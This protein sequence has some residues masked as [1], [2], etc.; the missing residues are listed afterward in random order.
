MYSYSNLNKLVGTRSTAVVATA[1]ACALLTACAAGP[2][3]PDGADSLR[4]RLTQLQADPELG[5]RAPLAMKDADIAVKAAEQPQSDLAVGTHLVFLAD[6]KIAIAQAQAETNFAVDQR[7]ALGEQRDAMRL[8]SR[9]NEANSAKRRADAATVDANNQRAAAELANQRS[10]AAIADAQNS[11]SELQRQIDEL[12]AEVT[13]RGLVLT[14]GDVLFA[15]GTA[16]LN[17]GGNNHLAKLAGFLNKYPERTTLIEG[18]T[19]S[20]GSDAYNQGLSQRRADAVK[21]Y[22]VAQGIDA[23]RMTAIGKGEGMPVGDNAS[24]TGRQLN[25]R[26]EVIIANTQLSSR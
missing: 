13:D 2:T 22:L 3:K 4:S 15:S 20:V 9:T 14:L 12:Q 19:D 18:H 23:S 11:A 26:V 7:K 21:Y 1:V 5:S 6:R 24:V 17:T 25:R 8:Q 10:A 16:D